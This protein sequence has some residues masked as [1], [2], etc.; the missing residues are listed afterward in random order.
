MKRHSFYVT[1]A[2]TISVLTQHVAL[3]AIRNVT[4]QNFE[5]N[6]NPCTF[7]MNERLAICAGDRCLIRPAQNT[8]HV[9]VEIILSC[10]PTSSPTGFENPAPI[11]KVQSIRSKN[12]LG[13]LSIIDDVDPV[14]NTKKREL[15]LCLYGQHYN[16]C[17]YS[18]LSNS[19]HHTRQTADVK[20]FIKGI[21]LIDS[22]EK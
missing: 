2:F 5:S 22:V 8:R 10:L 3:G 16:L 6:G 9:P 15:N 13:H 19:A 12:T 1:F 7:A 20:K 17:G 14:S 18:V 11:A 4:I 21:E